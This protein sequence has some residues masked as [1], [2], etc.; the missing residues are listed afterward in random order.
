MTDYKIHI[1]ARHPNG[2]VFYT[3]TNTAPKNL[4]SHIDNIVYVNKTSRDFTITLEYEA[5]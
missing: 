3:R 2:E 1:E 5:A 4:G